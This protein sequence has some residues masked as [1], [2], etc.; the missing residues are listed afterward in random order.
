VS[1]FEHYRATVSLAQ[2]VMQQYSWEETH[3]R[4]CP[5]AAERPHRTATGE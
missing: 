1:S 5:R 3:L 2:Y 4:H